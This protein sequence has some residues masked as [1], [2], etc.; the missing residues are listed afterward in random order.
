MKAIGQSS[1]LHRRLKD[2][3]DTM[4]P[5]EK[6]LFSDVINLAIG[7]METHD[8][9]MTLNTMTNLGIDEKG[10]QSLFQTFNEHKNYGAKGPQISEAKIERSQQ[11]QWLDIL[12]DK[13]MKEN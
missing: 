12:R 8:I 13:F 4:T 9:P 7:C 3:P 5:D 1:H 2:Q 11:W 6:K 10:M